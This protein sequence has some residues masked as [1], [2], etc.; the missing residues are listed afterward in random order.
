MIR[1]LV[2]KGQIKRKLKKK[3]QEFDLNLETKL[4]L[5]QSPPK[6]KVGERREMF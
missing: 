1:D 6:Q 3:R 4:L 2:T 5:D